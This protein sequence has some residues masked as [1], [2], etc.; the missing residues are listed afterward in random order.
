MDLSLDMGRTQVTVKSDSYG[1]LIFKCKDMSEETMFSILEEIYAN[2]EIE[3]FLKT[4]EDE[5][6]EILINH[7]KENKQC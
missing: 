1:D 5:Q 2:I 6:M 4:L 3:D 7:Y